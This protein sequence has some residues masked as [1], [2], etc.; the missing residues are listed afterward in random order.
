MTLFP[1]RKIRVPAWL[2]PD[3]RERLSGRRLTLKIPRGVRARLRTPERISPSDWNEKHR[4]MG[5]AESFPGKWRRDIAP[6]AAKVMDWWALPWVRELVFC[7]P[8]QASKTSAMLGCLGWSIDQDPGNIF[9]TASNED[10]S[11]EIVA[12]KLIPMLRESPKL[13]K[14]LSK[15]VDE[16]GVSKIKMNH[17]VHIRVAWSNSPASTASFSARYTFNDEVDKWAVVTPPSGNDKKARETSPIRRIRK[18]AK[19]YPLTYKHFWASTPAGRYIH[20]MLIA[21]QQVWDYAGRCPDCGQLHIMVEENFVIS[22]GATEETIKADPSVIKYRCECGS[23]WDE[24]KRLQAYREGDFV[25]TKGETVAKPIDIGVHLS[26]FITPDMKFIDIA[27]TIVAAK[28]GDLAAKIDLA[29]GV[30]AIDYQQEIS[31]RKEDTILRLRDGRPAGVVPCAAD[32]LEISIDTQDYGFW[33]RIRAWKYGLELTSW[34]VKAG[35]VASSTPDDFAA[36]DAVLAAEYP[37]EDGEPHRITA[38]IIDT[39]GHRTSE[40]YAWCRRT[41]VLAAAGAPGRKTQ[42]VTVSRIDRFPGN[43]KPIPG[44]LALYNIDTHYH[45]DT[46]SNKLLIDPTDPGAMVLHSGYTFDQLKA[47]G[48]DGSQTMGHNLGDYAK[49]MCSEYRDD[50]NL[51]QCPDGK[52]NHL[53]DCESNGL[54]LVFWLG[55]QHAVSDK[56]KEPV[57][58]ANNQQ[59]APANNLPG[60][61]NNR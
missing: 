23:E 36:L 57:K 53:W 22:E 55:W 24:E 32:D 20:K 41:G 58:Q 29:H 50:R 45:K 47:M 27:C 30:K 7:G 42:P 21:C 46:L 19:N 9:Y 4:I 43:G 28:A 40:V 61:F 17:G 1:E 14:R 48:R 12:D 51:W 38:G 16:T 3:R 2:P 44:G 39:Q 11:K 26:G 10:K 37:D 35:Y 52:A 15:R 13:R 59:P 5:S 34:L 54:A 18:R 60:W 56:A 25:C 31:E 33:Y 6:H 8:D 49:Q